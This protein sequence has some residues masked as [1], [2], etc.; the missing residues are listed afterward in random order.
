MQAI[1]LKAESIDILLKLY[2][3]DEINTL[4]LVCQHTSLRRFYVFHANLLSLRDF[5]V[6]FFYFTVLE[7]Q[8][9]LFST[10]THFK[11]PLLRKV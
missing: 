7:I 5:E 1:H 2:G 3:V 8:L 9:L 6:I 10:S 11:C 4:L